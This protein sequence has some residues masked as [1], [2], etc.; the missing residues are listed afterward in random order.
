[1]DVADDGDGSGDVDDVGLAHEDLLCLFAYLAEE[2]LVEE[3]LA[4]ELVDAGIE[5]EGGHVTCDSE[6][7]TPAAG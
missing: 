2:G 4:E 1:M 5:V 3:L 6:N 7:L